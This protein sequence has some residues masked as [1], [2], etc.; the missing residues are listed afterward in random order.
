V[1]DEF[2]QVPGRLQ[3]RVKGTGLGLSYARRVAAA[4][5]G[6]LEL[7]SAPD[8]GS[9]F[10]VTLP[11]RPTVPAAAEADSARIGTVLIVDDE[12]VFRQALRRL[13][14]GPAPRIVEAEDA[15]SALAMMH[16]VHPDLVLLDLHMPGGG[17]DVV[18][19]RMAVDDTLR[20][21]PVVVVTSADPEENRADDPVQNRPVLAKSNLTEA[22]LS[23]AIRTARQQGSP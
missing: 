4:L 11:V 12:P 22:A 8:T 18:L 19:R 1:F 10:T 2:F 20:S 9:T 21:I 16:N 6:A 15:Q 7:A 23:A 17:G 14:P 13:L 3:S 5:G